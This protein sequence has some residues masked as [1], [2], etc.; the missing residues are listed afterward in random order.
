MADRAEYERQIAD[1]SVLPWLYYLETASV[2][3]ATGDLLDDPHR[4]LIKPPRGGMVDLFGREIFNAINLH[5]FEVAIG[6]SK[7]LT[8]Y[9]D[10]KGTVKTIGNRYPTATAKVKAAL[11][12]A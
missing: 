10:S 5:L 7:R 6:K 1:R 4:F 9:K 2:E 3:I 11:G 8:T 12:I